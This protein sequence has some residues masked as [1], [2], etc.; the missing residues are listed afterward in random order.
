MHV[1]IRTENE[2]QFIKQAYLRSLNSFLKFS[3]HPRIDFAS[4]NL[5]NNNNKIFEKKSVPQTQI[6]MLVKPTNLNTEPA[7]FKMSTMQ[8][9]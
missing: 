3:N 6:P 7:N 2:C 1:E 5:K 4:N 9:K 8:C